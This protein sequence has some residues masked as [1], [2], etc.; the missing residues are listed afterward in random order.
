QTSIRNR[1]AAYCRNS[2][3]TYNLRQ[4]VA[5]AIK[6]GKPTVSDELHERMLQCIDLVTGSPVENVGF[7]DLMR[8][9]LAAG[10]SEAFCKA[11]LSESQE[12]EKYET[13]FSAGAIRARAE[14]DIRNIEAKIAKATFKCVWRCR[15]CKRYRWGSKW[16]SG[17][18]PVG[19]FEGGPQTNCP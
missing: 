5:E 7:S 15:H 17:S 4:L 10:A 14:A 12:W 6:T 2:N 18:A 16:R 19:W 13:P 8:E 11:L 1:P 3:G 9:I